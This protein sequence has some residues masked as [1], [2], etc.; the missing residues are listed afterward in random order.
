LTV[1]GWWLIFLENPQMEAKRR[2]NGLGGCAAP[3]WRKKTG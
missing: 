3:G 2:V 1:K